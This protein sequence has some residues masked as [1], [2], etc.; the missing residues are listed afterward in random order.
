MPPQMVMV[1]PPRP[2]AARSVGIA[3]VVFLMVVLGFRL[4]DA[5][6]AHDPRPADP[7]ALPAVLT[8]HIGGGIFTCHRHGTS[9]QCTIT[10]PAGTA[11]HGHRN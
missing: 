1:Q 10:P 3:L 2:S 4:A 6:G 9:Y 8:F 11:V 5:M 7:P